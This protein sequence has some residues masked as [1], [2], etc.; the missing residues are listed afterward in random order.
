METRRLSSP[1]P[2]ERR[3]TALTTL[4][5]AVVAPMPSASAITAAAVKPGALSRPRR[6]KRRSRRS[7]SIDPPGLNE[8]EGSGR[9]GAG[10]LDDAPVEER[11]GAGGEPRV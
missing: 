10:L 9:R 6:P 4:K 7:V 3:R 1:Q 2:S 11:D 5:M 8:D